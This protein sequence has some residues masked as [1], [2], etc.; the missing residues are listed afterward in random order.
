MDEMIK[1]DELINAI[2]LLLFMC[3]LFLGGGVIGTV[4]P[5]WENGYTTLGQGFANQTCI[6]K[7]MILSEV[8]MIEG[9]PNIVCKNNQLKSIDGTKY[10][11]DIQ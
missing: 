9:I 4:S 11:V 10:I 2:G 1:M 5:M 8:K 7:G 6:D 3:G